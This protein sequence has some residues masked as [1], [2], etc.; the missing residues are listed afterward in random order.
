M[1]SPSHHVS[2][3]DTQESLILIAIVFDIVIFMMQFNG[4]SIKKWR[5]VVL[6][7][8]LLRSLNRF[9]D[10]EDRLGKLSKDTKK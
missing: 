4:I 9:Y 10:F 5:I 3:Q 2:L 6:V 7:V 1:P 8:S